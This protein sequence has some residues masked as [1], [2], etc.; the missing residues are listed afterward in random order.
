MELNTVHK[1]VNSKDTLW[2]VAIIYSKQTTFKVA[3]N[4]VLLP[5][6]LLQCVN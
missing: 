6:H 2:N 1:F 5:F 3:Y 4:K